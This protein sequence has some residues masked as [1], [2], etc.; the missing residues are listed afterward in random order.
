LSTSRTTVERIGHVAHIRFSNPPHNHLDTTLAKDLADHLEALDQAE[1]CRCIVLSSEGS[2]FC[3]GVD[4][5]QGGFDLRPFYSHVMR[6]YRTTKPIIA[7][8]HGAAVGAGLG[9]AVLADFRISCIEAKF[10]ANFTR[11]GFH[12]GFGLSITLPRL[13]GLQR[14]TKLFYTGRRIDGAEALQMGLIDECV[15]RDDVLVAAFRLAEEI[16]TSSPIAVQTTRATL[17][18][19]LADAI[20]AVNNTECAHQMEHFA[21]QDFKEGI[22]AMAERRAPRFTGQ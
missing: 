13:I 17:R 2:V 7:A 6:M 15:D 5:G 21:T 11:L 20:E 1:D 10:S 12:P 16:A 8:I 9:L 19:G 22:R 14:A 4:F 18:A 3:A